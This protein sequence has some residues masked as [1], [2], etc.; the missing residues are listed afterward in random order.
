MKTPITTPH[1]RR[2]RLALERCAA[3]TIFGMGLIGLLACDMERPPGPSDAADESVRHIAP[4][5]APAPT[6]EQAT[7][8]AARL[9]HEALA[10]QNERRHRSRPPSPN[11]ATDPAID[12]HPPT[13][14]ANAPDP[15]LDQLSLDFIAQF[16]RLE[17]TL[18]STARFLDPHMQA[19]VAAPEGTSLTVQEDGL[20]ARISRRGNASALSFNTPLRV[21]PALAIHFRILNDAV[22]TTPYISSFGVYNST[23]RLPLGHVNHNYA[24]PDLSHS[25]Y[26][27]L[28][29]NHQITYCYAHE[30]EDGTR[31]VSPLETQDIGE[32]R[33]RLY[34]GINRSAKVLIEQVQ[35]P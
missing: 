11:N 32:G 21:G 7:A 16:D 34:L 22:S 5:P 17:P 35:T 9:S 10:R 8:D 2:T 19:P 12:R 25:V 13:A 27:Y 31:Y 6:Q 23:R 24:K 20:L 18:G 15:F 28:H 29:P 14:D 30:K 1:P 4:D 3:I 33:F 26:I